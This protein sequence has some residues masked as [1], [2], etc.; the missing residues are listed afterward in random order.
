[1]RLCIPEH[2]A[3]S[4]DSRANTTLPWPSSLA[5]RGTW[6]LLCAGSVLEDEHQ[7][8]V[9]YHLP[10]DGLSWAKVSLG[11]SRPPAV[12]PSPVSSFQGA[13]AFSFC[14][15][16]HPILT[17]FGVFVAKIS[18]MGEKLDEKGNLQR[19]HSWEASGWGVAPRPAHPRWEW[20]FWCPSHP[21]WPED[22]QTHR[23][24][25]PCLAD[26]GFSTPPGVWRS[27][28]GQREVRSGRLLREP[29]LIGA[30]LPELRPPAATH[31]GRGSVRS[32]ALGGRPLPPR[33]PR[34]APL[35]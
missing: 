33:P 21:L 34:P 6:S 11:P 16:T 17:R 12:T 29:D 24:A 15:N 1:M 5:L 18:E 4:H 25:G 32:Q 27:G 8:M 30:G 20:D 35:F 28:E 9:H 3:G 23:G 7:G 19:G 2:W 10:G 31:R 14:S 13:I 26:S 22:S